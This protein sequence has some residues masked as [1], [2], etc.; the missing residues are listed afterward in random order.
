MYYLQSVLYFSD[1]FNEFNVSN[2]EIIFQCAL[3]LFFCLHSLFIYI[4]CY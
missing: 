4:I 3:L 1:L 2:Y